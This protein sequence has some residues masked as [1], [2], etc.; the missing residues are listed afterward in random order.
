[1]DT[2]QYRFPHDK[3]A[4]WNSRKRQMERFHVVEHL[5]GQGSVSAEIGVYKGGFGE[6]LKT[7]TKTLYL[8]DPWHLLKPHWGSNE[9]PDMSS[10]TALINLLEVY[11][12][13]IEAGRVIVVPD[14][15][16]RFLRDKPD[17]F[18]DWVYLDASHDFQQ[19]LEEIELAAEKVNLGGVV[20]GDDYDPDPSS[21]QH[22][23][24]RA[25]EEFLA[26]SNDWNLVLDESRQ[27]GVQRRLQ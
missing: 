10:V 5:I 25:V 2:F 6:F 4:T 15:G 20:M 26:H 16:A 9:T 8:V 22:G 24:F 7:K 18:F 17:G 19:T 14:F 21:K 3:D 13:E 27:W 11:R 23:V 12:E 1:M